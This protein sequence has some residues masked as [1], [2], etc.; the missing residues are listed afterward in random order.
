[1]KTP[2]KPQ[3]TIERSASLKNYA[4]RR[5]DANTEEF[6]RLITQYQTERQ[7]TNLRLQRKAPLP[8]IG[9]SALRD[10][11]F[12]DKNSDT[13]DYDDTTLDNEV[14][15][16]CSNKSKNSR[17]DLHIHDVLTL[18]REQTRDNLLNKSLSNGLADHLNGNVL[19]CRQVTDVRKRVGSLNVNHHSKATRPGKQL[20][21]IEQT[22]FLDR[23]TAPSPSRTPPF[24]N[25]EDSFIEEEPV[26]YIDPS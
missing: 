2:K 26:D 23:P 8:E 4:Y 11:G 21:P 7:P 1:M 20:P 6:V 12:L 13:S 9:T 14:A 17:K 5:P 18:T 24:S 10:S 22:N 25:S 16:V 3:I 19:F 15:S